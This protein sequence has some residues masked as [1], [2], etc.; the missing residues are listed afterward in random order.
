MS[1]LH[2]ADRVH[3]PPSAY[4]DGP[5]LLADIGGTNARFALETAPGVIGDVRVYPCRSFP[6]IA[7]TIS[8]YLAEVFGPCIKH[9]AIAIAN[10]VDGDMV[11]MTNHDWQFSIEA[12]R[13]AFGFETLVVVNDF[14]A[15]AMTLPYLDHSHLRQV[16]GGT[17]QRHSV[18]GL[19]GAGTGLGVS[20]L[21]PA[22][23]RWTPLAGEGGH[24]SF[25]PA[26]EREVHILQYA[27]QTWSHVSFERLAAGPGIEVIYRA[28][29]ARTSGHA[30]A[31]QTSQIV[32]NALDGDALCTEVLQCFCGMLGTLAG[33]LALTLGATGGVYIG[34]GVVPRLGEI[35][36][37]SPFRERFEAKGR[38]SL[39]LGAIPTFVITVEHPAFPGVSALLADEVVAQVAAAN[40][41]RAER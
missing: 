3:L 28:L 41:E 31:L 16:G 35:F 4:I 25:A 2:T 37:N 30:S 1:E 34:G 39:Y 23:E 5:R 33:N 27:W 21:I 12:T 32:H 38:F 26:D 7:E 13:H 11:R 20:G 36:V 10:P 8:M 6:G 29:A 40:P 17:A 19:L 14:T 24:T 15:L 9:A 18:I 22:G